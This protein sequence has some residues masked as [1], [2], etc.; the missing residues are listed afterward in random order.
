MKDSSFFGGNSSIGRGA[1]LEAYKV[2]DRGNLDE[3]LAEQKLSYQDLF[4]AS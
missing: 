1:L 4:K 2:V 3:L